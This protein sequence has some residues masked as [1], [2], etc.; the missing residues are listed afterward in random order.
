MVHRPQIKLLH[1]VSPEQLTEFVTSWWRKQN[2]S[3]QTRAKGRVNVG[4]GFLRYVCWMCKKTPLTN[5]EFTSINSCGS[6]FLSPCKEW[7]IGKTPF[8]FASQISSNSLKIKLQ[9]QSTWWEKQTTS[10]R[11]CCRPQSRAVLHVSRTLSLETE[12]CPC[13]ITLPRGILESTK[14]TLCG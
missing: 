3:N 12:V 4:L 2:I 13:E 7:Q 11:I 5:T 14:F 8:L 10:T 9:T 1:T 6:K